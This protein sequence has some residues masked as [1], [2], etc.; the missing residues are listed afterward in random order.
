MFLANHAG[1]PDRPDMPG[2]WIKPTN[3]EQDF[4]DKCMKYPSEPFYIIKNV[5]AEAWKKFPA[6]KHVEFHGSSATWHCESDDKTKTLK[7]KKGAIKCTYIYNAS[8]NIVQVH[9]N[10]F[11]P[12]ASQKSCMNCGKL[13]LATRT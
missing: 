11:L 13:V 1:Q 5:S 4:Q 3:L 6:N 8:E 12:G 10:D 2:Y 9:W 7:S